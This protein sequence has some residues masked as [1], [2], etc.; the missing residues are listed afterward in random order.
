MSFCIPKHLSEKLTQAASRGEID[1]VALYEM[2]STER[3]TFFQQYVDETTAKGINVGFERAVL[4]AKKTSLNTWVKNTFTVKQEAK[5]QNLL[6]RIADLKE[7]GA[8]TPEAENG[9]LEDLVAEKLGVTISPE[10]ASEIVKRTKELET[11]YAKPV[12]KFGLPDVEY[13][14]KRREMDKYLQSLAPA[15]NLKILSSTAGRGAMLFSLKSPFINITGNSLQGAFSALERRISNNQYS[16]VIDASVMKEYY[17]KAM[18]I[19]SASEYDVTR[20]ESLHEGTKTLGETIVHSQGKGVVRKIGRFYEDVVFK[21]LLSK[22]D[23]AFSALSFMDMANLTA[24]R[25]AKAE[26]LTGNALK[27]RATELFLDATAIEP[28][29]GLKSEAIRTQAIADATMATY[30]N[31]SVYTKTALAVREVLN[32][33]IP[34]LR[35]GD[36]VMPFVKTVANVVGFG[37]DVA[38]VGAIRGAYNLPN[39]VAEFKAGN[40]APMK[41]AIRDFTRSGLGVTIG[42]LLSTLVEPEDFLGKYP[43]SP[44]E[45]ELLRLNNGM[46]NSIRV[47]GKWISLEYFGVFATPLVGFLYAKKYGKDLP[48]AMYS[49]MSGV[50]AQTAEIPGLEQISNIYEFTK[51]LE[52]KSKSVDELS[53]ETLIGAIKFLKSRTVPGFFSDIAKAFDTAEREVDWKKPGDALKIGVPFLQ[54][55]LPEKRDIF[56]A[57]IKS[58]PWYSVMLFGSRVKTAQDEAIIKE[59]ERLESTG[60]LPAITRPEKTSSRVKEFKN[61]VDEETFRKAMDEFGHDF[62]G[63]V[64][65]LINRP[66]Y[67][68]LSDEKKKK[69]IDDIKGDE[70]DQTLK[71]YGY[72]KPKTQA[73]ASDE[74]APN[75][76]AEALQGLSDFRLVPQAYAADYVFEAGAEG[77]VAQNYE[78]VEEPI[79]KDKVRFKL[80]GGGFVDYLKEQA[81]EVRD[82][83]KGFFGSKSTY[84]IEAVDSE[85]KNV[86]SPE[87]TTQPTTKPKATTSPTIA[88]TATPKPTSNPDILGTSTSTSDLGRSEK[89]KSLYNDNTKGTVDKIVRIA[90]DVGV[91]PDVLLDIAAQESMLGSAKRTHGHDPQTRS[92]S[93]VFQF[94]SQTWASYANRYAKELGIEVHPKL[95]ELKPWS[96]EWKNWVHSKEGTEWVDQYRLDESINIRLASM[97]IRDGG[98]SNWNESKPVWGKN[99][100]DKEIKSLAK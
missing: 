75:R 90:K 14:V 93:G 21:Q 62:K 67:N 46:A 58:E 87:P 85:S 38:G 16:G 84:V 95:K 71:K 97:I 99:Y 65:L 63:K 73:D 6:D 42:F 34:D 48:S 11:L 10:E 12:D 100:T 1:L 45:R 60:N 13:F 37:A 35:I 88:P 8:L 54:Q 77:N 19:Y 7:E 91:R 53:N 50:V 52:P 89:F 36:Q 59:F 24:T 79:G 22:P 30:Q 51:N 72:K 64:N 94:V 70:L 27:K 39:A 56:G 92:A 44:S 32:N 86:A 81:G 98:I 76:F 3:R 41:I 25:L 43:T 78:V 47:G 5:K 61:Q 68:N 83:F 66:G 23:V 17:Q 82:F 4:S 40:P 20:L 26:G 15:N 96:D 28:K 74:I 80:P 33:I 9:F 69:L 31:D 57:V 2:N 29:L 18:K 49:Y 55:S